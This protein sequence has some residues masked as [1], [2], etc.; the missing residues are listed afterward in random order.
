MIWPVLLLFFT[1]FSPQSPFHLYKCDAE[2]VKTA[3]HQIKGDDYDVESD[4]NEL[5][6]NTTKWKS[7]HPILS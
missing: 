7:K 2:T 4:Y 6:V 3:M 5:Q 1:F